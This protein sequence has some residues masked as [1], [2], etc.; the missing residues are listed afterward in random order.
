LLYILIY[1]LNEL[2]CYNY[3]PWR[4]KPTSPSFLPYVMLHCQ[5]ERT[6]ICKNK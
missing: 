2:I 1:V 4:W 6:V 3:L 5:S